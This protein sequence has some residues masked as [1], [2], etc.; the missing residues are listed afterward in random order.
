M[1][2]SPYAMP[3]TAAQVG[4]YF[5]RQYYEVLQSQPALAHQFYSDSSTMLRIDGSTRE[6]YSTMLDIHS[7]IMCLN[8]TAIEIKTAH[9][10][11]SWNCGVLVMVSGHLQSMNFGGARKFVETFFLA[12]QDKGYFVLNDVFHFIEEEQLHHHPGVLLVQRNL[13]SNLNAPPTAISE[14]VSNY[15]F[16]GENQSRKFIAP[17]DAVENGQVDNY[18]L[19]PQKQLQQVAEPRYIAEQDG[20][21]ES[22][23]SFHVSDNARQDHLPPT[24]EE[25]AGEPQ[26][27]T[28]ASILRV[29]KEQ[30]A[31][32]AT[33]ERNHIATATAQTT[34]VT[35]NSFDNYTTNNVDEP[36]VVE[37]EDEI[38]SVYVRN[39]APT[40]SEEEIEE[41]FTKFGKVA[42]EGVVIRSRQDVGVC[43]AF[44]EFEDMNGV[45]NAVKAGSAQV[46]G[47]PVYIEERRPNSYIPSRF[48]RGRGRGRGSYYQVD[49]PR[50]RFGSRSFGRG[51]SYDGEYNRGRGNGYYR[52]IHRQDMGSL[53]SGQNESDY[54]S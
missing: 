14:P 47:R 16:N 25:V 28:Y 9:A 50:G 27:H 40:A 18:S 3:V 11:E 44:V 15:L 37:D 30:P 43:Y 41:E 5:V 42:A 7:L 19:P 53:E 36:L 12:P 13:D 21:E 39:L 46:A 45:H 52:P 4:T 49:A 33:S 31:P 22:N 48:G 2:A 20:V 35:S 38:R 8:Y 10:L 34:T 32:P 29:A 6:S 54:T 1:M 51:G 26:K 23:G 17:T 24:L